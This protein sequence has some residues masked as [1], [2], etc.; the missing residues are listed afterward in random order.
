VLGIGTGENF[1][2]S[3]VSA[4]VA[5]TRDVVYLNDY[6][7]ACLESDKF[8][9]TSLIGGAKGFE[10]SRVEFSA[11]MSARGITRISCSRKSSSSRKTVHDAMRGR[12]S[13]EEAT[14]NSAASR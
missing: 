12:L 4:I 7:I 5:H 3:D 11:R 6:D 13:M 2:A 8:E 10:V 14:A 9:I 1:L